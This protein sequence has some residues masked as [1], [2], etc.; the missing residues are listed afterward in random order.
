ML[1]LTLAV[2]LHAAPPAK[3]LDWKDLWDVAGVG[4]NDTR[5]TVIKKWGPPDIDRGRI[6]GWKDGVLIEFR[7]DGATQ[8]DFSAEGTKKFR[9]DRK[10]ALLDLVDQPCDAAKGRL[11]LQKGAPGCKHYDPAGWTIEVKVLCFDGKLSNLTV[12]WTP[13][14]EAKGQKQLPPDECR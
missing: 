5:E 4:R 2:A 3:K 7:L 13:M 11:P 14:P 6:V 9:A 1:A 8:L 12:V 10:S